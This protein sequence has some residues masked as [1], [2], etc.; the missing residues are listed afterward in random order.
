MQELVYKDMIDHHCH[1]FYTE[2][3]DTT[4]MDV[5]QQMFD[6]NFFAIIDAGSSNK[7]FKQRLSELSRFKRAFLVAGV[8]PLEVNSHT[9]FDD[10]LEA[11]ECSGIVGVGEI[12]LDFSRAESNRNEQ[13]IAFESQLIL[14]KQY[15]LPAMLHIRN[16]FDE[17]YEIVKRMETPKIVVH[18]FTGDKNE[19]KRWLNLGA[20]LSF[21]G[22]ITFKNAQYLQ[23]TVSYVPIDRMFC[24]TDSP[25]LAPMPH[26][27]T[28]NHPA[29]VLYV[30]QH[31]A[32]LKNISIENLIGQVKSSFIDFYQIN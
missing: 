12:G 11:L 26:R 7:S 8:H 3:K 27:G 18:C 32:H 21:S 17:S 5:L 16:S 10:L 6:M 4:A 2:D 25:Y 13:I 22:M 28:I 29:N 24:E 1:M 15:N 31:V 23:D 20:Y 9:N 19:A 30:Y 14:A